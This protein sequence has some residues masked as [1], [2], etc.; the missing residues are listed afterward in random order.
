MINLVHTRTPQFK[1]VFT[2]LTTQTMPLATAL[3]LRKMVLK[4]EEDSKIVEDFQKTF[5]DEYGVEATEDGCIRLDPERRVEWEPK[6]NEFNSLESDV[7]PV[8]I[9]ELGG[10]IE[11]S[12]QELDY[13]I[14]VGVLFP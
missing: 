3:K 11:L 2:K 10:K 14:F 6:L 4:V 7:A 12:M 8:A 9:N 5:I 1:D 13:L